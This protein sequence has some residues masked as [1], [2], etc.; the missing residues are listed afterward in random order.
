MY[1]FVSA[2]VFVGAGGAAALSMFSTIASNIEKIRAA[3]A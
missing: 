1:T 2:V 3:L